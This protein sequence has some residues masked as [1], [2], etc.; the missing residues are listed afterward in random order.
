MYLPYY[1]IILNNFPEP[2]KEM[3]R[4]CQDIL[5]EVFTMNSLLFIHIYINNTFTP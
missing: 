1:I 3:L 2:I 5:K 4:L